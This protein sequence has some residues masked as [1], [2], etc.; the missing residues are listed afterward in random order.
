MAA[1]E[2]NTFWK[3][4]SKHGRRKLFE[5]PELLWEAACEYF[6]WCDE[7]PWLQ[8]KAIQKTTPVPKTKGRGKNKTI[9][10]EKEQQI[11]QEVSPTARPYSLTGFCLYIDASRAYWTNFKAGFKAKT[12]DELSETDKDFLCVIARVEETIETQ[13]FEGA[14]VGAFNANIIARKLGLSDKQEV[15]HTTGGEK[16]KGFNFLPYTPEA[17][18]IE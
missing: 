3:L 2:G 15:D 16:F 6:Q 18:S 17:D 13:Q 11:H 9:T 7:N 1:P 8:K 4:R 5:T 12:N 14:V 10:V